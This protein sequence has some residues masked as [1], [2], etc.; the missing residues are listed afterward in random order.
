MIGKEMDQPPQQPPEGAV[1]RAVAAQKLGVGCRV[2]IRLAGT[3]L[4]RETRRTP[5]RR[6]RTAIVFHLPGSS[7]AD[8]R[9][10][11][12][13]ARTSFADGATMTD[14]GRPAPRSCLPARRAES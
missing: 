14:P 4:D 13:C 2:D 5:L 11:G 9:R 1:R 10:H 8:A 12:R 6:V 7:R 3:I